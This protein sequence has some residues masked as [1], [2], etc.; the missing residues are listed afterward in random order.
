MGG[1][2]NKC[3]TMP[4]KLLPDAPW[5]TTRT[6]LETCSKNIARGFLEQFPGAGAEARRM[7]VKVGPSHTNV[8]NTLKAWSCR[9]A[10]LPATIRLIVYL[11]RRPMASAG[12]S[13]NA[14][15]STAR[16]FHISRRGYDAC[17]REL[18]RAH[19]PPVRNPMGRFQSVG[20]EPARRPAVSS[21]QASVLAFAT[22][23]ASATPPC[24]TSPSSQSRLSPR[25]S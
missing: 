9:R 4:A 5:H 12:A 24:S 19:P 7:W 8:G 3:R 20:H 13:N 23:P 25:C 15:T 2:R 17:G 11:V 21:M 1:S 10:S 22:P 16:G 18:G 14:L 6:M